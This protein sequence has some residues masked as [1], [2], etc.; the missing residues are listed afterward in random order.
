[1]R[2]QRRI[3]A[4]GLGGLL[5]GSGGCG[6]PGQ[7]GGA[8]QPIEA[9]GC[10]VILRVQ[11]TDGPQQDFLFPS[12]FALDSLP[13]SLAA[14]PGRQVRLP[15]D[16]LSRRAGSWSWVL[17]TDSITVHTRTATQGWRLSFAVSRSG[18][19]GSLDAWSGDTT[20]S[21]LVGGRRVACPGGLLP[22]QQ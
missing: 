20:S 5:L 19:E 8:A 4:A 21:W 18:L 15:R 16:D 9:E 7:T 11:Q 1:M 12:F 10:Y 6:A 17:G 3:F 22:A 2:R 14:V 13:A